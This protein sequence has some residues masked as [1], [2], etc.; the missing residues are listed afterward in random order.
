MIQSHT[1]FVLKDIAEGS[2]AVKSFFRN[3]WNAQ[4]TTSTRP[5]LQEASTA[6]SQA[7]VRQ[8]G[9]SSAQVDRQMHAAL[10]ALRQSHHSVSV[11]HFVHSP[12]VL[13]FAFTIAHPA[14]CTVLAFLICLASV[15]ELK[16]MVDT[17]VCFA[18]ASTSI[19]LGFSVSPFCSPLRRILSEACAKSLHPKM[20]LSSMPAMFD[21]VLFERMTIHTYLDHCTQIPI[22]CIMSVLFLLAGDLFRANIAWCS[23]LSAHA[24]SA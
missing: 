16:E 13:L 12:Q 2:L 11:P 5:P 22:N 17:L 8:N 4:R 14:S 1:A 18:D 6:N 15:Y 23:S 24:E 10:S 21:I 3:T 7:P 20:V 9:S 19:I